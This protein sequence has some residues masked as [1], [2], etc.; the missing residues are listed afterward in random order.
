MSHHS[1]VHVLEVSAN[2]VLEVLEVSAN[3]ENAHV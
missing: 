3:D 2:L 1:R